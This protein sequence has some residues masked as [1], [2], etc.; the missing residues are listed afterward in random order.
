MTI[1]IDGNNLLFRASFSVPEYKN[2]NDINIAAINQT[3]KLIRSYAVG[4]N[5]TKVLVTWDQ[6]IDYDPERPSFRKELNEDY[7]QNRNKDNNVYNT[8]PYIIDLLKYMGVPSY[9]PYRMEADDVISWLVQKEQRYIIVISGDK[10][11]LQLINHRVS[12]YNPYQKKLYTQDNFLDE[13]GICKEQFVLYKCIMGDNSDNI[14]GLY[15]YGEKKAKKLANELKTF[16]NLDSLTDEQKEII[17]NNRKIMDLNLGWPV[18]PEE[19]NSY[20]SQHICNASIKTNAVKFTE[21]LAKLEMTTLLAKI[22]AH[23]WLQPFMPRI[24]DAI[25]KWFE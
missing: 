2:S 20:E 25:S 4:H 18:D 17:Q 8:V 9:Y 15:K 10:D 24:D 19:L 3:L 6:K 12:V 7:K 14:K 16:D 1:I 23:T 5:A 21:L 13:I 11:L 22:D